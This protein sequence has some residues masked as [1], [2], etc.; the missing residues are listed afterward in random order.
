MTLYEAISV[1]VSTRSFDGA[2]LTPEQL[3]DLRD[4]CRQL[5]EESTQD[6][7]FGNKVRLAVAGAEIGS[8]PVR[9]GTYG[10]I[11]NASGF[12]VPAVARAG[13][14]AGNMEDVGW[15]VEKLVLELTAR[16]YAT[17]WIGG[18]FS[19]S[20]A[21]EVVQAKEDELVPA[22]IAF[23]WP[24]DRRKLADRVVTASARARSR[25][26]IEEI[27]FDLAADHSYDASSGLLRGVPGGRFD[28]PWLAVL[29]AVQEA[30][31]ASNKQPWRLVR[32]PS[33]K[34]LGIEPFAAEWMLFLDEDKIYNNGTREVHLQNLDLGIAMRHFQIAAE[35]KGLAGRWIPIN[36]LSSGSKDSKDRAGL[37]AA[38]DF[39]QARG[40]TA[41]ALW[42]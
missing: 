20:R 18:V 11:A 29:R 15:T 16:G 10:L 35:E 38:L 4:L 42:S 24:A 13:K 14:L 5:E 8:A 22:I 23:G 32:I 6:S 19:R 39:G 28:E 1:R 30:P 17:C 25:K 2:Q 12:V 31:S 40:W 41:C 34:A 7:P 26:P 21:A 9:M 33:G 37:K 3:V 27:A 36:R